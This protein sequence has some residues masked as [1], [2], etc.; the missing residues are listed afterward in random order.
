[1]SEL[2]EVADM[3]PDETSKAPEIKHLLN[4]SVGSITD[5]DGYSDE[6]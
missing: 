1:M 3:G 5:A 6:F 2:K 4:T